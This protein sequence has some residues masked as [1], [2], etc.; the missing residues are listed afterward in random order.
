MPKRNQFLEELRNTMINARVAYFL[1]LINALILSGCDTKNDFEDTLKDYFI[2]YYGEDGK[3]QGIDM[4]VNNDGTML[5]LGNTVSEDISRILLI[6]VD[7]EGNVIWKKKFDTDNEFAKDIEP[8]LNNDGSVVVLSNI[9]L[10]KNASTGADEHDIHLVVLTSAGETIQDSK[11]HFFG[12][13]YGNS[14]TPVSNTYIPNG[15]Y[16][17]SGYTT[18]IED[19]IEQVGIRSTDLITILFN[20]SI[21]DS[22]WTRRIMNQLDG[23]VIKVIESKT[24]DPSKIVNPNYKDRPFYMFGYSDVLAGG[25]VDYENNFWCASLNESGIVSFDSYSGDPVK[26]ESMGQTINAF[27]SGFI[28]IGT[29]TNSTNQKSLALSTSQTGGDGLKFTSQTILIKESKNLQAISITPSIA[30]GR[31]LVLSNETNPAGTTNLWLSKVDI[32]GNVYWSSSF[33]SVTKNDFSGTVSELPD[34]KIV[35][36]GTIE[37]ESQNSK[38]A[39]IK[40]NANGEILN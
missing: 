14:V 3:Q 37:L 12:S 6:K 38:M 35:I 30:G 31:Y 22:V 26:S 21:D 32:E 23:E 13:Q 15:G 39:L 28:S 11:F 16:I 19:G 17:V 1:F 34:G 18:E 4:I 25:D 2:K 36:F 7:A 10:K 29:Q 40:L 20:T 33:G 8:T 24:Y 5:L 9:F 27:G